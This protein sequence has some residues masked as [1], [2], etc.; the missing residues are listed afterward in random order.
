M[1]WKY[2]LKEDRYYFESVAVCLHICSFS[3]CTDCEL[4]V[5]IL[6]SVADIWWLK[7]RSGDQEGVIPRV[8]WR[9]TL[10]LLQCSNWGSYCVCRGIALLERTVYFHVCLC[11]E[12]QSENECNIISELLFLGITWAQRYC[13]LSLPAH[14]FSVFLYEGTT[15]AGRG[16]SEYWYLSVWL[17]SLV[18]NLLYRLHGIYTRWKT[19][20]EIHL[21]YLRK[22]EIFCI[23][24]TCCI[25]TVAL[26]TKCW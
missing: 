12:K 21:M 19:P 22:N 7:F 14:Q 1:C 6:F 23:F 16:F 18:P 26:S 24:N 4:F 13:A 11:P 5:W 8:I 17:L 15:W 10:Y 20:V 2:L 25:I 9:G 3:S